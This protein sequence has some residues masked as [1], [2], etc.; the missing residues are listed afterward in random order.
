M[1]DRHLSFKLDQEL[2]AGILALNNHGERRLPF[3]ES[4]KAPSILTCV[5]T[6]KVEMAIKLDILIFFLH[7]ISRTKDNY[8]YMYSI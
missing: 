3:L 5:S 1:K 2:G 7:T 4:R 8:V 6:K